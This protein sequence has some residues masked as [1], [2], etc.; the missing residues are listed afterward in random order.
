MQLVKRI[1]IF[2]NYVEL[3]KILD[4]LEKAGVPDHSV[5]KD[6]ASKST[7]GQITDDLAMTMLDNVY[8]IAFFSP[9]KLPLVETYIKQ[10]LNKFGG[11]CFISDAMEL[12]TT[13]CVG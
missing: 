3:A 4:A 10:I 11:T 7:R 5:I 12:E 1:E 2:A 13:K 9:E 6:V 8:I